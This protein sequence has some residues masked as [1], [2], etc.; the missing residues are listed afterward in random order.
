[1]RLVCVSDTHGLHRSLVLP[2]GDVLV[3]AGDMTHFGKGRQLDDFNEWL[4]E[5]PFRVKLVVA[6]NHELNGDWKLKERLSNATY[7]ESESVNVDDW[8]VYGAPFFPSELPLPIPNGTD[9]LITHNPPQ[10]VGDGGKHDKP[11]SGCSRLLQEV[12]RVRP[13][14]H[15]F[16]H[17]HSG[18]GR[19][20][21]SEASRLH[22][23]TFI[24]AANCGGPYEYAL[25]NPPL[26][27]D[28]EDR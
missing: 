23:T 19:F 18:F 22:N 28:M 6:G 21:F 16:G 10:G 24:N 25:I 1:M 14:L 3:H 12:L 13:R 26:V 7:L 20:S 15:V 8:M 4:G 11:G 9:I 27:F 5:L 17:V 2:D